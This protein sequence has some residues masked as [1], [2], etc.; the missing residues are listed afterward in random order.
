MQ[1]QRVPPLIETGASPGYTMSKVPSHTG[2]ELPSWKP[3]HR[4]EGCRIGNRSAALSCLGA[5][6]LTLLFCGFELTVASVN[7]WIQYPVVCSQSPAA[8][9]FPPKA[10]S[11]ASLP[12]PPRTEV[13]TRGNACFRS[14]GGCVS[15]PHT[16]VQK[17]LCRE[18]LF[19]KD[20]YQKQLGRKSI[21]LG[22]RLSLNDHKSTCPWGES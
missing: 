3:E 20:A 5:R 10:S 4:S 11:A 16:L 7:S 17:L 15:P 22:W 14:P 18:F 9:L 6:T 2:I 21:V 8:S 1:K 13:D 19:S 12:H